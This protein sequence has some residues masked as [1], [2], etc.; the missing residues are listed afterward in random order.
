[1]PD[2]FEILKELLGDKVE[3]INIP[4]IKVEPAELTNELSEALKLSYGYD[5]IIFTS[6]RGVQHFFALYEKAGEDKEMLKSVKFACIGESTSNELKEHGFEATYINQGKTS[7]D[8]AEHLIIEVLSP[9]DSVLFP[10]GNL[11]KTH[12]P[13]RVANHCTAAAMIVYNTMGLKSID[14]PTLKILDKEDY[15]LLLFTSPSAFENYVG[16]TGAH[17]AINNLKIASIGET[18]NEA[19]EEEGFKPLLTASK[20]NLEIF[21]EDILKY[22]NVK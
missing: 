3:L 21:A 19:I 22:L 16:I 1:M 14:W 7:K 2:R 20:P 8:F 18:T 10:I 17:P 5:W 6:M 9:T 12:L 13:E 15:D 4:M 11:A